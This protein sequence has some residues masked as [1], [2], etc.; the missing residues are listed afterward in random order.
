MGRILQDRYELIE[1]IGQ[2]GMAQVYRAYDRVLGRTVAIKLML[3]HLINKESARR[4]F[5][6][7]AKAVALLKL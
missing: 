4:R 5:E 7:E 6:R 2:G 3:P 1:L